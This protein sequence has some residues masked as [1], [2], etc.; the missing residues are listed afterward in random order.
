AVPPRCFSPPPKVHS[1]VIVLDPL[2][3]E[4]LPAP[5]LCRSVELLLRAAF[6]A[7]RK[8]LHNS[9]AALVPAERLAPLAAA[10]GVDLRRRPQELAPEAW[11]ALAA[12]LNRNNAG[13]PDAPA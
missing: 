10:A 8:M 12:G 1:E 4:Q 13:S 6:A 7:R 9:L 2:A 11:L 3:P 5:E